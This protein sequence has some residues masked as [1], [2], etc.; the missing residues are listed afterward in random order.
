MDV[1][2]VHLLGVWA[3]VGP[4]WIIAPLVCECLSFRAWWNESW[5]NS[6]LGDP[7]QTEWPG[8]GKPG[9][10]SSQ[11]NIFK[12]V[13]SFILLSLWWVGYGQFLRCAQG[14][15]PLFWCKVLD[16]IM[17]LIS[18]ETMLSFVSTLH[19]LFWPNCKFFKYFTPNSHCKPG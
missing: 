12:W 11:G 18:S 4:W 15:F 13:Y 2:K 14:S 17:R 3:I 6:F 1:T 8:E 16:F 5:E 7:V 10:L 19:W 9:V